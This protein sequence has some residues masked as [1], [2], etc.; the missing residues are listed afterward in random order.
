M[1]LKNIQRYPNK[2]VVFKCVHNLQ[3]HVDS[4]INEAKK[5][6]TKNNKLLVLYAI[7]KTGPLHMMGS[8]YTRE[9]S[10]KVVLKYLHNL[11]NLVDS[12][13]NEAKK[14]ST[15][16]NKFL[17]LDSN[18]K[19]TLKCLHKL[20]NPVD[21]LTNEAKNYSTT[22]NDNLLV[23]YGISQNPDTKD[24]I[25]V[26]NNE[27]YCSMCDEIYT[28]I[29]YKWCKLCNFLYWKSGDNKI[30]SLIQLKIN[31]PSDTRFKWIPYN[32]F[33]KIRNIG[34][35]HFFTVY[36]AIWNHEEVA[37]VCFNDSQKFLNKVKEYDNSFKMY[38]I[39][40][41]LKK[42]DYILVLENEYCT[43]YGKTYCKN[44]GEKYG[45]VDHT[46]CRQC[47]I[48]ATSIN[49]KGGFATV[50]SAIWK[51]GPIKYDVDE[52]MCT[53]VSNKKVAL[54]CLNNSQNMI[55]KF[56]SEVREYS[57]NK[58]DDILNVYGVSQ[59]PN[60]NDYII[61]IEYA[62]GG[63]YNNW[64]DINYKDFDWGNKIQTLLSI[65][66]A[67]GKQ[68]FDNCAHDHH[69]TLAIC[70]GIRPEINELEIP[71]C[72]IDLMK[73]CWDS[74]PNNRPSVTEINVGIKS[75]YNFYN[76]YKKGDSNA[77]EI[78]KQFKEAEIYRKSLPSLKKNKQH[79][80]AIYTSRLL[81]P[82]TKDLP[83]Y[84]NSECISCAI[85]AD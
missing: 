3:N 79:P 21:Y 24:Y 69:L 76:S 37:L 34:K 40:Q 85:I 20:Q 39:S 52:E 70:D 13:I 26:L 12:L 45:H 61:V 54:K 64:I 2:K 10:K 36:S 78:R 17:V 55:D 49:S 41:N 66:E 57:I 9:S 5:Y 44:C 16:N 56:L 15:K 38:G 11:Q 50:Y 6:S 77:T 67:T 48:T 73:R 23:L 81:D 63:S 33:N 60:T 80:E 25:L 59:N 4:I 1:R 58:M 74:N 35:G 18:K 29:Q 83:K 46:W 47:L 72:Y 28:D 75:F 19:I 84:D 27:N 62:D 43:E 65:I 82:F 31:K 30:D 71:K 8:S 32:Q 68:P 51:D 53:R 14:Y 42:K 7:W 22:N